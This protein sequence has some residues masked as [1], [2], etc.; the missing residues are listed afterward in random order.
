MQPL[1][2]DLPEALFE[3]LIDQM[4]LTRFRDEELNR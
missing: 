1:C 4:A 2:R 3:E